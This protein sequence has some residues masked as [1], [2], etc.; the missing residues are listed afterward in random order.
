MNEVSIE[1]YDQYFTKYGLMTKEGKDAIL[2]CANLEGIL[3]DPIYTGK[4]MAGMVD[5]LRKGIIDPE[6]TTFFLHTG[7]LPI[8]FSFESEIAKSAN[9][10]KIYK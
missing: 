10:T 4:V 8:L 7:G 2:E 3:L 1:S 6:I 5:L 9:C